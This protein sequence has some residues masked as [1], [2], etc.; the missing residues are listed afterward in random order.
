[1]ISAAWQLVLF[2]YI[3]TPVWVC[4]GCCTGRYVHEVSL[5][6]TLL[7]MLPSLLLLGGAFW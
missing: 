7:E 6:N 2:C 4:A 5:T 1:M 3:R